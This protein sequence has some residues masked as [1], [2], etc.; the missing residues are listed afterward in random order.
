MLRG[1]ATLRLEMYLRFELVAQSHHGNLVTSGL[2]RLREVGDEDVHKGLPSVGTPVCLHWLASLNRGLASNNH[3]KYGALKSWRV[4]HEYLWLNVNL[5][6]GRTS[7][8]RDGHSVQKR[9]PARQR[10]IAVLYGRSLL[11][12]TFPSLD[13]TSRPENSR[14]DKWEPP[15]A[16]GRSGDFDSGLD[17]GDVS[18][19]TSPE[20]GLV[21]NMFLVDLLT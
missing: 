8:R 3:R 13:S 2:A 5:D 19:R 12:P 10:H 14:V 6:R 21:R 1:G 20:S 17:H 4:N 7:V 9:C 16:I 11:A 18:K 15:L